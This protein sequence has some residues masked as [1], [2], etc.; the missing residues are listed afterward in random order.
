MKP[1]RN[2][3]S[4]RILGL[5]V[6]TSRSVG[7]S[8]YI[9][10]LCW[11]YLIG[12]KWSWSIKWDQELSLL[13]FAMKDMGEATFVIGIEIFRDISVGSLR[14]SHNAY[15]DKVF[16]RYCMIMCS[17]TIIPMQTFCK[18]MKRIMLQNNMCLPW[19]SLFARLAKTI[20]MTK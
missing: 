12:Q 20:T 19:L 3:V 4:K 5:H 17:S 9:W 15:I 13:N 18:C 8:S 16:E 1:L 2:S 14:L 7:V 10:L 6:Y 11:W